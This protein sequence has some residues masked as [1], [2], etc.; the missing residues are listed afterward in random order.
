MAQIGCSHRQIAFVMGVKQQTFYNLLQRDKAVWKEGSADAN[1]LYGAMIRG[2]ASGEVMLANALFD[3]A[4]NQRNTAA[5]IYLAK[6]R[7]KWAETAQKHDVN[8]KTSVVFE[9]QIGKDGVVRAAE[10]PHPEAA[11][12]AEDDGEE[13]LQ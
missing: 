8:L 5:L 10:L 3:E 13:F 6:V 1:N 11:A 12:L 4:V 2:K 7:L 9:T